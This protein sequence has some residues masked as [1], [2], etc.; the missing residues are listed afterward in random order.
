MSQSKTMRV[1]E[2]SQPGPPD[3]LRW[4]ER[5][6]PTPGPGEVLLRVRA[7]GVNRPD[8]LQRK[9]LYPPPPGAPDI[10]GLEVCGD[11]VEGDL[12]GSDFRPGQRVC[13]LLAGGGYADWCLAPVGQ[14]L[15]VPDNLDDAEAA[16]LPETY[17]TVWH[18]LFE[19]GGLRPGETVLV[20]G[21]SSGIGTTAVQ[22]ATALGAKV[23]ATAGTAEKCRACVALGAAGAINYREADFVAEVL[24]QTDGR[25][26]DV[27]LDMVAGSYV[28]R[29]VQCLADDGRLVIIAVQGGR[30]AGFDASLLMRKRLTITGSTL[31]PRSLAFKA[32]VARAL[33]ETVWPLLAAGTVR[34]SVH[35]VLPA[36]ELVR[37]HEI[38]EA[39]DAIGKVV[40]RWD[41]PAR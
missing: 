23:F 9:G 34:P 31:R 5:A 11:I 17:F 26:V 25:G 12:A 22:L 4:V 15:P 21:G 13:A 27:V 10:P 41:A 30:E 8:L 35:A 7:F 24:R 20:H 39:G 19:R 33:R 6:R 40:L 36:G 29:N 14:C 28:A 3:V 18:N 16:A 2:I 38:L 37:A 32:G 1:A